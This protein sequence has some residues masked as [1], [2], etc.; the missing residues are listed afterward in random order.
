MVHWFNFILGVPFVIFRSE[1]S[2]TLNMINN[3][4]FSGVFQITC[5]ILEGDTVQSV[6]KRMARS[7]RNIKVRTH[8]MF[9]PILFFRERNCLFKKKSQRFYN[10]FQFLKALHSKASCW[11]MQI[12][13]CF[14]FLPSELAE[15]NSKSCKICIVQHDAL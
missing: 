9:S 15:Q 1:P 14:E 12:L 2:V 3:Q 10:L 13:H 4:P 8:H 5:P 7:E 11:L 6:A